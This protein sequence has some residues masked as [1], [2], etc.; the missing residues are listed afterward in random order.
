VLLVQDRTDQPNHSRLVWKDP[1]TCVRI[2][3][4]LFPFF[5]G[6]FDQSFCQCS[7]E[8]AAWTSTS[9]SASSIKAANFEKRSLNPSGRDHA[10]KRS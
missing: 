10:A 6:L 5:S 1:P 7:L 4:S 8:E 3:T 2:L 9:S